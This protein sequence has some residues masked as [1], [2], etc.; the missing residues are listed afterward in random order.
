MSH[1][2]AWWVVPGMS[3]TVTVRAWL[4]LFAH[5]VHS[6]VDLPI[7]GRGGLFFRSLLQPA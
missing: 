4:V 1:Y 7:G 5:H 3:Q 2:C 6:L